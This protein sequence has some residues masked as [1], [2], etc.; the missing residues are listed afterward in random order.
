[1]VQSNQPREQSTSITER[2]THQN[3]ARVMPPEIMKWLYMSLN[4]YM[5]H[6]NIEFR[7]GDP[8]V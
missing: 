3:G 6:D 1:V 4:W 5:N 8:A 7:L 2:Y